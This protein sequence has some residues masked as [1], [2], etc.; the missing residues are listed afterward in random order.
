[1]SSSFAH[2]A[3]ES[4]PLVRQFHLFDGGTGPHVL[5]SNGSRIYAIDPD[6]ERVL[7]SATAS[8]DEGLADELL[9]R[10]GLDAPEYIG[11]APPDEVPTRSLSL[12]IAQKCNLG[13]TYCYAQ[14]GDFGSTPRMMSLEVALRAV[15]SLVMGARAGDRVNLAFLGGEPLVNRSTLQEVTEHASALA[16]EAGV[17]VGF[18]ITTNGTLLR[19]QDIDFFERHGF[20]VTVSLDGVGDTH[21]Q[22]RPFKSGRP[23]YERVMANVIPLLRGKGRMQVSA[24]VTVTPRNL[25]LVE[26]LNEFIRLGFDSVGFSPM[27]SSPTGAEELSAEGL[28]SMLEQM[29]C[30]AEE[31]E[32]R[33]VEG[34]HYP[35]LNIMNALKEIH[36]GTHRPYPCGAGAGYFGVSADGEFFACHRFVGDD[37]MSMGDLASGVDRRRQR[38]WLQAR[39][40]HRQEPCRSCWARYLCGGGCHH[41]VLRRGR[42]ACDYIR[43]WLHHCLRAYVRLSE[44]RPDYLESLAGR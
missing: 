9:S 36:M 40:V 22:L 19:E 33:V 43:G 26:T 5:V 11:D 31:F 44:K 16:L 42:V 21:D 37:Q 20:A 10:F 1:V 18:S 7:A 17:H 15:E 32:W 39:H 3:A 25:R 34:A 12:A 14:Q 35:F 27:L 38:E 23:S 41:E 29:I 2:L 24:R 6:M 30:C 28:G 13:C 4:A 8:R